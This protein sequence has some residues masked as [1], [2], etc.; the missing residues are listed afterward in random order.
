MK[1]S[2]AQARD[3][4]SPAGKAVGG[5]RNDWKPGVLL[6]GDRLREGVCALREG[7][8]SQPPGL[9]DCLATRLHQWLD[10]GLQPHLFLYLLFAAF[11]TLSL[12]EPSLL[13]MFP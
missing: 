11:R 12:S 1:G 2:V 6:R 5:D 10:T 9:E 7:A 3:Q 4:T 13:V 8:S